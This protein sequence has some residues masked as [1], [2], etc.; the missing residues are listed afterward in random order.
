MTLSPVLRAAGATQQQTW[1][2]VVAV[3][4]GKGGVGKTVLSV[5]L[6]IQLAR[7]GYVPLLV[8]LDPGLANADVHLRLA[9]RATLKDVLEGRA[10]ARDCVVQGPGGMRF[11]PGGCGAAEMASLGLERSQWLWTEIR[12]AF[13]GSGIVILDTGAGIGPGPMAAAARADHVIV[14]T[15]PEPPAVT[16][17]YALF[18]LLLQGGLGG[19]TSLVIN[20]VA[21]ATEAMQTAGKLRTVAS[22]FLGGEMP[23]LLGWLSTDGTVPES[24]RRQKPFLLCPESRVHGEL[25]ALAAALLA[26]FPEVRRV[27]GSPAS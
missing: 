1:P 19:R 21:S 3:V 6:S 12:Q 24:V 11:L 20:E 2:P 27:V 26:R 18:K 25:R 16:D 23:E 9:P 10:R 4:S 14:V 15:T 17:A 7:A 22:R 8:D 5:N 13:A